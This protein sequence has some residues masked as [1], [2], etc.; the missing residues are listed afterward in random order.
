MKQSKLLIVPALLSFAAPSL[1]AAPMVSIGD[2]VTIFF[3]GSAGIQYQ[4]NIFYQETGEESDMLLTFSPGL[5]LNYGQPASRSSFSAYVRYDVKR[6][7]DNDNL[8]NENL[9]TEARYTYNDPVWQ[10]AAGAQFY[11]TDQNTRDIALVGTLVEREITNLN[12]DAE[13]TISPKTS[14]ASGAAYGKTD[15]KTGGFVDKETFSI[16]V[17]VYYAYSEKLDLSLGYRYRHTDLDGGADRDD[18]FFNL[19]FRGEIYPKLDGFAR[20]GIQHREID[21]G[22]DDTSF[23]MESG[24]FYYMTPKTTFDFSIGQDFGSSAGGASTDETSF[25]F[26]VNYQFN[27]LISARAGLGYEMVDYNNAIDREDDYFTGSISVVYTPNSYVSFSASYV[28][29]DNDSE[30]NT[31]GGTNSFENNLF[32]LNA[33]LRY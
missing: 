11:E 2:D 20:A 16:P 29:Q 12:F 31:L 25:N 1:P 6:W 24:L 7:D 3:N 22:G 9:Y 10:I 5:E 15:Y 33:S 23:A 18:H 13:Y 26:G 27:P 28:Y 21:G 17:N 19:G 14:I 30:N 8:D 32:S 4:S